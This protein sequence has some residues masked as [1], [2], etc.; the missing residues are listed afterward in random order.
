M[1]RVIRFIFFTMSTFKPLISQLNVR[2][3]FFKPYYFINDTHIYDKIN[4]DSFGIDVDQRWKK[5]HLKYYILNLDCLSWRA[6]DS[7]EL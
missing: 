6:L 7:T 4:Y 5:L 2:L 3:T 1:F